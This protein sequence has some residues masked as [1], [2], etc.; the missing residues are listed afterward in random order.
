[1]NSKEFTIPPLQVRMICISICIL[2]ISITGETN[3]DS[4]KKHVFMGM[5]VVS[6]S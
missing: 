2:V 5:Y 3:N 1:M 4:L 6:F